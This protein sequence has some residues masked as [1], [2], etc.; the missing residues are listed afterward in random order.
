M[1]TRVVIARPWELETDVLAVPV[2]KDGTPSELS[3]ELD[4]RLGSALADLRAVG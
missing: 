3:A 4:R 2:T 1:Q